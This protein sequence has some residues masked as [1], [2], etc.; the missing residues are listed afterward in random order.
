MCVW[1]LIEDMTQDDQ[2]SK[3]ASFLGLKHSF[4]NLRRV[5][6]NSKSELLDT[7][8]LRSGIVVMIEHLPE[9]IKVLLGI[10]V[11][12]IIFTD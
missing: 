8:T 12:G 7:S 4:S 1:L 2:L 11:L 9:L 3:N 5:L 6:S 10:S